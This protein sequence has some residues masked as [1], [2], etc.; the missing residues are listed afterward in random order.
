MV[1]TVMPRQGQ[2]MDSRIA[3]LGM[4]M[5]MEMDVFP[6]DVLANVRRCDHL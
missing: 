5:M 3:V 2:V 1:K 4:K 6:V